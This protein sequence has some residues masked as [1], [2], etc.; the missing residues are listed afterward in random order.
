MKPI[1]FN[2][3]ETR[4][5]DNG[6]G[7][8]VDCI[9]C[10]V[11]EERNGIFECE[12]Q[13][14]VTGRM[15]SEIKEGRIIG[16]IHDDSKDIQPFDI[17]A[18]ST[19]LNGIVTFYA[20][21]ISYRLGNVILKPMTASSC[22]EAFTNFP[23]KTYN[24]CPFSFWTDKAVAANWE[25]DI[26]SPIKAIL[27]GSEG[28]ILDIYGKGEYEWDK[29]TVKLHTNR[30]HDNGVSIRYGV[31]LTDLLH[32]YDIS[33]S[34]NAVVPYWKSKEDGTL[35]TLSDGYIAVD[36]YLQP[37][38][39]H[40]G[41]IMEDGKGNV[42]YFKTKAASIAPIPMDLSDAFENQPTEAQLR[43]EA[44][45]RLQNSEAWLPSE[46]ITV[47][48]VNLADTEEYKNISAL[49]R[50]R[51]CDKVSVYC[52]PLGVSAIKMLVIK[53][54]YDV[55]A[56]R[57]DEIELGKPKTRFADTLNASMKS[58]VEEKTAEMVTSSMM[59]EAIDNA[60][61]HIT[62]AQDSHV[63]FVYDANG[64][65]QEILIMDTDSVTTATKVWRW[66]SGGLGYSS[67]GYAGP[68]SLA[69]T[70]DG[71]IVAD[72][73]TTGVLSANLIKAGILS[74][75]AG[76]NFWNLLTGEFSLSGGAAFGNSTVSAV[77]NAMNSAISDV[78]VEYA[79]NQS[80]TTAP[81]SG[82]S[83][84]AP[85][86][87][88]GYYIWQRTK[89]TTASGTSYSQP[90]CI[91]GRDGATGPQGQTGATGIGV[92]AIVE[93]Y[94]LSTSSTSQTG[95]SWS[96]SQPAWTSGKYIWTRSMV[97]WTDNTTTY[98][99]PVLAQAINGANS[100]AK[101]ASDAVTTL[102]NN[103][104]QQGV[105][106][107]LTNN[108]QTQGIYLNNGLLYINASYIKTG[109]IDGDTVV[110]RLINIVDANNNI[111]ASFNNE[112]TL[113]SSAGLRTVITNRAFMLKNASNDIVAN[114]GSVQ[115]SDIKVSCSEVYYPR[116]FMELDYRCN[117]I[118]TLKLYVNE[119]LVSSSY[120]SLAN[121]NKRLL[122]T[123]DGTNYVTRLRAEY[124]TDEAIDS[125][126]LGKR[127]DNLYGEH[128]CCLGFNC[129]CA[130]SYSNTEGARTK[131]YG[132]CAHAEGEGCIAASEGTH[133][134]GG[135]TRAYGRFSHVEG[136]ASE[137]YGDR[138]H[139]EGQS[140]KAN[141]DYSHAQG[142]ETIANGIAQHT[143]GSKNIQDN[144]NSYLE[145]VGNAEVSSFSNRSNARTL[146][147]SGNEW[148]AGTLTQASDSRLKDERGEVPDLSDV[149]ARKFKW[150]DKKGKHDDKE[151]IGYYAQDVEKVAPYLVGEDAMGFKSLD[152]NGVMVAKI[153]S[154]EKRVAELERIIIE[155]KRGE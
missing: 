54:V 24:P 36:E 4:F 40:T 143:F 86:W 46:N 16:I 34:Y 126:T 43:A 103:L 58:Y 100:T 98:T 17:Y 115:G 22:V 15:F 152:Y 30:G 120:Y 87:R 37:W 78:D 146:D 25:N 14:P 32:D 62:G 127:V 73:I 124:Y 154:L 77:I 92:S 99:T 113:G 95:G 64:G 72:M 137:A 106:N 49:Q 68:Y 6:R 26:P 97:T 107:R 48:F 29:W 116:H 141:G 85:A 140:T 71:A 114:I 57:Y 66:N 12:F 112:I 10:V 35:V 55:L 91:S 28:S 21:H 50:V 61:D 41:A 102:D 90:T 53:V 108:G 145:I 155:M 9:S 82:W 67:N 31:N 109:I 149:P 38:T 5:T 130:G 52:G 75:G 89:T 7:R 47:Q 19:P 23:N 151:H 45:R 133:A 80:T 128:S 81:T 121:N 147:W 20:H 59:Q 83:T 104:D 136:Q 44:V 111:I 135:G 51:L 117:D 96:T 105:F 153:A 11:T 42:I 148:I 132:E 144:S 56:E 139:A 33:G 129:T 131:T 74:D 27:G 122:Y 119:S 138:G 94:Y 118:S 110:A 70:Q 150:N 63:T 93:Q 69:M 123:V 134:E 2:Q 13:Y 1:L 84:T 76:K 39:T 3:N 125:V 18:H 88:D 8:L 79:Q 101:A 60:T 65:L 142:Y